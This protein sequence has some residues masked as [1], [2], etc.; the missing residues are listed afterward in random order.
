MVCLTI[1]GILYES[2]A[3]N[4]FFNE[5]KFEVL[6]SDFGLKVRNYLN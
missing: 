6:F 5:L 1:K 2:S 3:I 4:R